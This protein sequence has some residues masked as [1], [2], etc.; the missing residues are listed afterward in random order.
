M[1]TFDYDVSEMEKVLVTDCKKTYEMF[2]TGKRAV[3][4]LCPEIAGEMS[5]SLSNVFIVGILRDK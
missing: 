3:P 4:M 1:V 5:E 2:M